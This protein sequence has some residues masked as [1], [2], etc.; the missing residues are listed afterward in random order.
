MQRERIR[1]HERGKSSG[2]MRSNDDDNQQRIRSQ[3]GNRLICSKINKPSLGTET[4]TTSS[5]EDTNWVRRLDWSNIVVFDCSLIVYICPSRRFV[6]TFSWTVAVEFSFYLTQLPME[7]FRHWKAKK[8]VPFISPILFGLCNWCDNFELFIIRLVSRSC[9]SCRIFFS[10]EPNLSCCLP[11][12]PVELRHR[13][14]PPF[15]RKYWVSIR[16]IIVSNQDF[17]AI[18]DSF[19]HPRNHLF[20]HRKPM[21]YSHISENWRLMIANWTQQKHWEKRFSNGKTSWRN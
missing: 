17:A 2:L 20:S 1:A 19:F 21:I 4:D 14:L 11:L 7:R 15:P 16:T 18:V 10:F 12:P 3:F 13:V 5:G 9:C 8:S 6:F